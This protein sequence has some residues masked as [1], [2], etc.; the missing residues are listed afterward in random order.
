MEYRSR[1][2]LLGVP[3]VHIS[4]GAGGGEPRRGVAIGWIALGDV[5]I[6]I[7]VACGGVALGGLC[8][9]GV[10][11]G[12]MSI[13]GVAIGVAA[14]GG[15]ALGWIAVGGVAAGWHAAIG[16]LAIARQYAVGGLAFAGHVLSGPGARSWPGH[17]EAPFRTEDALWLVAIV[18][19]LL[20]VGHYVRQRRD[21]RK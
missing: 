16:G 8:V 2:T 11:I 14:V 12:I 21:E 6:G 13:G 7:V 10:S 9:G 15:F 3:L 20:L 17:P 19:V 4:T 18:G 5:A 1:A